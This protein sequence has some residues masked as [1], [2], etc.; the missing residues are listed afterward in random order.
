MDREIEW[1][2]WT[3]LLELP[4][5]QGDRMNTRD[6][7]AETMMADPRLH[8]AIAEPLAEI[9]R[10]SDDPNMRRRIEETI[11][12]YTGTQAA[13]ADIV[14][15]MVNV[16]AG[17]LAAQ[18]LTSVWTLG[19][20]LAAAAA[21]HV[22]VSG[23]PL[24]ATMGG[25]WYS[26]FPASASLALTGAVTLGLAATGA[27]VVAFA[28]LLADPAQ[29]ALGL[30]RRRLNGMLDTLERGFKGESEARFAPRDHY[31]ARII[32]FV[33]LVRVAH[34]AVQG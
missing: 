9:A 12:A 33:D 28:G 25:L 26:M 29:R 4:F 19:P 20:V 6:A 18:Q 21:D 8:A 34:K 15:A 11:A 7:L 27:V 10:H 16:G 3:E 24:G 1:R 32:D 17:Y 13:A 30:H 31:V 23:F 5:D 2:I 22:A 14:G